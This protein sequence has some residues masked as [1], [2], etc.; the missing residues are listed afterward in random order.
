MSELTFVSSYMLLVKAACHWYPKIAMEVI[1]GDVGFGWPNDQDKRDNQRP[2]HYRSKLAH[3]WP[4]LVEAMADYLEDQWWHE[5]HAG[6]V[7]VARLERISRDF[8]RRL[9][10]K[11]PK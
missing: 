7:G 6:V 1:E 9:T 10:V 4:E 11:R 2:F 3:S 5:D 8:R